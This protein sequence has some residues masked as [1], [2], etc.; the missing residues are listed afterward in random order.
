MICANIFQR[1]KG[2][3]N[4]EFLGSAGLLCVWEH[5]FNSELNTNY[6]PSHMK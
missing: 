2:W 3:A 4:I 6:A 5:L 1:F